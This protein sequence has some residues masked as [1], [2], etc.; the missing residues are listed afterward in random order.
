MK[1]HPMWPALLALARWL[2]AQSTS[3]AG[4]AAGSAAS[5][6]EPSR[7]M[8]QLWPLAAG[9]ERGSSRRERTGARRS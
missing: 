4:I 9:D 3:T 7:P 8:R 2:L 5:V 6:S 1:S